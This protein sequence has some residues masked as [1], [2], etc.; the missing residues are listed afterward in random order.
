M[1]PPQGGFPIQQ[2]QFPHPSGL[3][4]PQMQ[5]QQHQQGSQPPPQQQ[6]QQQQQAPP[7]S[8]WTEHTA[9]D[10]R[11]YYYNNST[12]QS[13]YEKPLELL[14]P[15]VRFAISFICVRCYRLRQTDDVHMT[16]WRHPDLT[17]GACPGCH[18]LEGAHGPRWP[19]ILL[20]QGDQREQMDDARRAEEGLRGHLCNT[21]CCSCRYGSMAERGREDRDHLESYGLFVS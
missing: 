6:Q 18:P 7:K 17:A 3:P 19:Q 15:E 2:Q 13:T 20:Q 11:K 14:P 9:P 4:A 12:K 5:P 8:A 10:G 16:T 21:G 1:P